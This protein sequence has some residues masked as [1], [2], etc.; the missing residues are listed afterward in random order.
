MLWIA[1]SGCGLRRSLH[2]SVFP[3]R[4]SSSSGRAGTFI[5]TPLY[6]SAEQIRGDAS[7]LRTD[8]Y[9][10]CATLY[11]LLTGQAPFAK[12]TAKMTIAHIVP[13]DPV[14]PRHGK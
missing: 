12:S 11:F 6:A 3:G 2:R 9:S 14:P 10:V 5:G 8:I 7:D 4:A 13:K 1:S